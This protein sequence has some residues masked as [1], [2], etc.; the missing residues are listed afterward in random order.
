M[1]DSLSARER[2][3]RE[4]NDRLRR[5]LGSNP[6]GDGLYRW[7]RAGDLTYLS[8]KMDPM[9]GKMEF[10]YVANDNGLLVAQ[11]ILEQRKMCPNLDDKVWV[12]VRWLENP[13]DCWFQF[14]RSMYGFTNVDLGLPEIEP[15]TPHRGNTFTDYVIGLIREERT[16]SDADRDAESE[17]K[18]DRKARQKKQYVRDVVQDACSAFGNL[19]GTHSQNVE[20]GGIGDS[21]VFGGR[22]QGLETEAT[23]HE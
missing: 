14:G 7:A 18:A 16:K 11:P 10:D 19:E 22:E 3:L 6:N 5:E 9:T 4:H 2:L 8:A 13:Q 15:W 12:L 20:F 23:A 17:S 21:P 1:I